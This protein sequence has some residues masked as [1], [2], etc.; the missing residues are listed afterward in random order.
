MCHL[1]PDLKALMEITLEAGLHFM[2]RRGPAIE[3]GCN[4]MGQ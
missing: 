3:A 4:P 2:P 1:L